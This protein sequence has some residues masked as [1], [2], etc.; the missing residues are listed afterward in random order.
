VS[1]AQTLR[2]IF[3]RY[4]LQSGVKVLASCLHA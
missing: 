1:Q 2:H 3:S 4:A